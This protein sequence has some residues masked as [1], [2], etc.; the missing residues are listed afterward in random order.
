MIKAIINLI[1]IFY[2]LITIIQ[3]EDEDINPL[4][5]ELNDYAKQRAANNMNIFPCKQNQ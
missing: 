1:I 5:C 3:C 4:F 2:L